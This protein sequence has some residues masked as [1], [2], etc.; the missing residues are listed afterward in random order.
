MKEIKMP[1]GATLKVAP[2]PFADSKALF[3][4]LMKEFKG[5]TFGA[6]VELAAIIKDILCTGIYSVEVERCL[7]VCMGRC[8]YSDERGNLKIDADTFEP[9]K[10]REDYLPACVEIAK[11]NVLP[12]GKSLYAVYQRALAMI[13]KDPK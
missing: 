6:K 12:F 3:Q 2:S 13:D 1:S 9:A 8:I 5:I 11:E 7:T 4:A 10:A